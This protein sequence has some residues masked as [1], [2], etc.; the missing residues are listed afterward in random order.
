M[1]R[2]V[3]PAAL[4]A[5]SAM[6]DPCE[7]H[8]YSQSNCVR[9]LACW[10]GQSQWFDGQARGWDQGTVSGTLN[11]GQSCTGWWRA[12]GPMGVGLG[13]I[14]C[15]RLSADVIYHTQDNATGT[16]IGSGRDS[17]GATL[18][19]WSGRNVLDFLRDDRGTPQL[20]CGPTVPLL[21]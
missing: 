3:L 8:P 5:T 17:T 21:G 7:T 13:H 9:V 18:Q 12:G 14:T 1:F 16:V 2:R 20:P 10:D 15:D 11:D 6:A 4:C 19:L